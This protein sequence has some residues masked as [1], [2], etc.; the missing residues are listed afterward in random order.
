MVELELTPD[1]TKSR[2]A[3]HLSRAQVDCV[4]LGFDDLDVTKNAPEWIDNI[5]GL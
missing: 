1:I 4:D 5:A 3:R 2:H